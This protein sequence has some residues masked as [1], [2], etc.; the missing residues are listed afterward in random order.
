MACYENFI[1]IIHIDSEAE[2]LLFL[3][4]FLHGVQLKSYSFNKYKTKKKNQSYQINISTSN[5]QVLFDKNKK[6]GGGD[7][8]KYDFTN[9][10]IRRS[11]F[12]AKS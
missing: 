5:N 7:I 12:K 4:E 9:R 2:N 6:T 3:D 1:P 11:D 10:C 8:K